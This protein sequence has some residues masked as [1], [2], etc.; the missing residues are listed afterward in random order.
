MK[1]RKLVLGALF[2]ALSFVAT[3][4]IKIPTG[5]GYIHAGD[6]FV[7]LAGIFLGPWLG[8]A[9]AGIGSGLADLAAGYAVF[10]PATFIIKGLMALVAS[11]AG[12]KPWTL[13]R[14]SLAE[15][16]MLAGYFAFESFAFSP[17]A[18]LG[19][20]VMNLIQAAFGILVAFFLY[21][22]VAKSGWLEENKKLRGR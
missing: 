21:L 5:I 10:A 2:I 11:R 22:A 8:F 19:S 7:L 16:I 15:A 18:A 20:I 4:F 14:F 12:S 6:A 13:I 9:A 3:F 1:T 17:A